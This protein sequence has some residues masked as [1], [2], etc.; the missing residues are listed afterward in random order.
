MA[1]PQTG[2][3]HGRPTM[4]EKIFWLIVLLVMTVFVVSAKGQ[5]SSLYQDA[6]PPP[7]PV[8]D[9]SRPNRLSPELAA[10]ALTAVSPPQQRFYAV[11]DLVTI[12][13]RESTEAAAA[14][15]LETEKKT[16]IDGGLEA[17]PGIRGVD[18]VWNLIS[19]TPLDSNPRV[20]LDFKKKFEGDGDYE[21]KDTFTS[22]LTARIM[23]VKPN[24]TLVL[25]AR[26]FIRSDKEELDLVVTGVC[27]SE[28][29]TADNTVLSTQI[30]DLRLLKEHKG[31]V[32][33]A[34][35][36]GILTK[37]LEGLFAF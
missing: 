3:P 7:P 17:W 28:D 20:A 18:D 30:Y 23:D 25:E 5:S 6:P 16:N 1:T 2:R 21:R 13:I 14:A 37:V 8:R 33:S 9:G 31:E 22:R 19:R 35:K 15:S 36:K 12:V 24:G 32:R 27:R 29:I 26:K 11:N 4:V 34:S 10:V